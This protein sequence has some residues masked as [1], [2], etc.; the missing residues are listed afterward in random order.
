M[1]NPLN[2]ASRFTIARAVLF[3]CFAT[4][5]IAAPVAAQSP[6]EQQTPTEQSGNAE[7]PAAPEGTPAPENDA[8]APDAAQSDAAPAPE[9]APDAQAAQQHG[10][11]APADAPPANTPASPPAPEVAAEP[12]PD[13]AP[14]PLQVPTVEPAASEPKPQQTRGVPTINADTAPADASPPQAENTPLRIGLPGGAYGEAQKRAFLTP[15]TEGE[16][17]QVET[18]PFDGTFD[19]F[20]AHAGEWDVVNID[21]ATAARG[22][23]THL[24]EI[25]DPGILQEAPNGAPLADDF[26]PG[27]ISPCAIA[28]AAWSAIVVYDTNAKRLPKKLSDFFNT[29]RYPGKRLLPKSPRFTL[30][31]ALLASGVKPADVY[32]KLSTPEGLESAFD[33]LAKLK[34]HIQWY[35]KPSEAFELIGQKKVVMGLVFSGRAFMA[36]VRDS[37]PLGILWDRQ[38][39]AFDYWGIPRGTK[40]A[41]A[42]KSFIRFATSPEP[43]ANMAQIFPYGPA[44]RSGVALVGKHAE[45]DIDMKQFLPTNKQH[46]NNALAFDATWWDINGAAV[47]EQFNAWIEKL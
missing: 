15:F 37:K 1:N 40:N 27:A 8:S 12:A 42:A 21:G 24:L 29:R 47:E 9:D 16:G 10:E 17:T 45:V 3:A 18:A 20:K 26:F 28:S 11:T 32:S 13:V 23:R 39:Y 46:I 31:M 22:C 2:Y 4:A 35:D 7:T 14:E 34:K 30:E 19:A 38:I 43:L 5:L 33:K 6:E 36:V 41:E 25:L 44:R